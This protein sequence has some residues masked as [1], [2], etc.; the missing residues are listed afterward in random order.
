MQKAIQSATPHNS[1]A[2]VPCPL[3]PASCPCPPACSRR[4]VSHL[5]FCEVELQVCP[6]LHEVELLWRR[7]LAGRGEVYVCVGGDLLDQGLRASARVVDEPGHSVSMHGHAICSPTVGSHAM[8]ATRLQPHAAH[9]PVMPGQARLNVLPV[10]AVPDAGA[11]DERPL[12]A[13]RPWEV[14][15]LMAAP[16]CRRS[17]SAHIQPAGAVAR[18]DEHFGTRG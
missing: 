9:L 7:H 13:R 10:F 15:G 18:P 3:L 11:A 5:G 6:L 17:C 14:S 16:V 8:L 2:V 4:E 12:C 1:G